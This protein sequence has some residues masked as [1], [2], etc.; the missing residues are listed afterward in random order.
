MF[1]HAKMTTLP[2]G[3]IKQNQRVVITTQV[4]NAGNVKQCSM[5]TNTM[6]AL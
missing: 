6:A 4:E 3:K 2:D 5:V 1:G